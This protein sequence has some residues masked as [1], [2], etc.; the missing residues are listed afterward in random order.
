MRR[1]GLLMG[2]A[3]A[4]PILRAVVSHQRRRGVHDRAYAECG[5]GA[6][7]VLAMSL[8]GAG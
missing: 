5:R 1:V 8:G 2:F 6:G 4:L 3:R 7:A